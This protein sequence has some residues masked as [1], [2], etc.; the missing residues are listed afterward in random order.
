MTESSRNNLLNYLRTV[1]G[2]WRDDPRNDAELLTRFSQTRDEGAFKALVGRYGNLVWRTC[3]SVLGDGPDAEDAFQT[4]FLVLARQAGNLRSATLVGW[5]HGVARR[6]ALAARAGVR[7]RQELERRLEVLPRST[8]EGD[9]GKAE[10]YATLQEELAGLPVGNPAQGVTLRVA[11]L[12]VAAFDPIAAGESSD[13]LSG[14]PKEVVTDAQGHFELAGV[15]DS[16]LVMLRVEDERYAP[17]VLQLNSGETGAV[18]L[19][20]RARWIEGRAIAADTGRPLAEVSLSVQW[21]RQQGEVMSTVADEQIARLRAMG[22][23]DTHTDAEG[24]FRIRVF[25]G[26]AYTLEFYPPTGSPY[27]AIREQEVAGKG[28]SGDIALPRGVVVQGHLEDADTG[29]PIA[30]GS[31]FWDAPARAGHPHWDPNVIQ[32]THSLTRTNAVGQFTL[33][34]PAGPVRLQ[35]FGPTQEYVSFQSGVWTRANP[36]SPMPWQVKPVPADLL[37]W[38]CHASACLDL[39]PN[40]VPAPVTLRLKKGRTIQGEVVGADGKPVERYC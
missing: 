23:F 32:D 15:G 9:D 6:V 36:A 30:N 1:V 8:T 39:K 29:K 40:V 35:A 10:L 5:L 24:R 28:V 21:S 18:T 25:P 19:L 14:W 4:A 17:H 22:T 33:T 31:I 16:Q 27:L 38:Y 2:A 11:R 13:E 7:R 3:R 34:V 12:G 26:R 37:W 20:E